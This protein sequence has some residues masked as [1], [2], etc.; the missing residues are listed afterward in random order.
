VFVESQLL[1]NAV[2]GKVKSAQIPLFGNPT[3]ARIRHGYD[4]GVKTDAQ[5]LEVTNP[6]NINI[7]IFTMCRDISQPERL[8]FT[9][10]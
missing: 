2:I 10:S 7:G 4:Y 6:L 3:I 8:L 1:V 5:N 9:S